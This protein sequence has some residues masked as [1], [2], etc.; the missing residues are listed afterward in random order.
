MFTLRALVIII[1]ILFIPFF[2]RTMGLEPYPA[3][4]L[5]SGAF[6]LQEANGKV[7]LEF[8]IVYAR[9]SAGNWQPINPEQLLA[10]I[11]TQYF[12]PIVDHDFGFGQDSIA[13]KGRRSKV[14]HMLHLAGDASPGDKKDQQLK[15]WLRQKLIGQH[16]SPVA[17]RI[18]TYLKTISTT[19]EQEAQTLKNEKIILLDK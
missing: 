1:L 6:S 12:F 13:A 4:L 18:C 8:K 14:L 11:P 16:L 5:P 10:P 9:D 2:L 7:Q 3:I 15:A 19:S 17:I